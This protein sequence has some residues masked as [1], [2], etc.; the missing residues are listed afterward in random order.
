MKIK[1]FRILASLCAGTLA[2]ISFGQTSREPAAANP[3]PAQVHTGA[4]TFGKDTDPALI[5]TPPPKPLA[6][7]KPAAP[8][9]KYI[10]VAGHYIPVK[11][12]WQWVAGRWSMPPTVESVWIQGTYDATTKHWSEG[13]WQ[14]DGTPTPK[15]EPAAKGPAGSGK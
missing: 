1:S 6:E 3:P 14:P 12:Q 4:S 11:G 8:G 2:V 9:P 15:A 10:W 5:A 7:T 13:H